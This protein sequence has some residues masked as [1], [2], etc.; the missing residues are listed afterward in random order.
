MIHNAEWIVVCRIIQSILGLVVSMMT[1]RYL[2]PSNYGVISYAAS[3]VAFVTPVMQLG[4][5]SILVQEIIASK[6][7][8]GK[9]IGTSLVLC[10]A[11]ATVCICGILGFACIANQGE[12]TTIVVCGLYSLLL[13]FQAFEIIQY[14]FQAKLLSKYTSIISLI[15]YVCVSA[16]KIFL[17]ATEKSVYWFAVSNAFD[18]LIISIGLY[19]LYKKFSPSKLRF[20]KKRMEK[21]TK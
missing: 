6:S 4:F 14:W 5:N 13:I 19:V 12:V 8:E 11:S 7:S 16:Y 9:I 18:Y 3:L 1:A 20:S 10:L 21:R 2:G 15:A 17:L